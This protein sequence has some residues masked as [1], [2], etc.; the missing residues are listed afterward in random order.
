LINVINGKISEWEEV[1]RG[2]R[3]KEDHQN[4]FK[5]TSGKNVIFITEERHWDKIMK[6][7]KKQKSCV[8]HQKNT[9][10]K[11]KQICISMFLILKDYDSI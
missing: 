5:E 11:Q 7:R 2:R 1:R 10:Q 4:C 6:F 3:G 8:C 9:L